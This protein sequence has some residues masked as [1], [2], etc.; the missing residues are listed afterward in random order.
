MKF[1]E[2]R[3]F[4]FAAFAPA[5]PHLKFVNDRNYIAAFLVVYIK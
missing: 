3:E 1:S 5:I 4:R 2:C